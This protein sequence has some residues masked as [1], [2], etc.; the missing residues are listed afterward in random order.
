M[1]EDK[2]TDLERHIAD[3]QAKNPELVEAMRVFGISAAQ[4]ARAM[5]SLTRV[6]TF[7]A[8]STDTASDDQS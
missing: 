7:T 1:A 6:P 3:F 5:A 4:Y 8:T 2:N